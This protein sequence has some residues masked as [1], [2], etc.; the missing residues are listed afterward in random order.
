MPI[1]STSISIEHAQIDGRRYVTE[2]H[3]DH[4]GVDHRITYL[5]EVGTDY[6]SVAAA[7][8]SQIEIALAE[9]EI[10]E[11]LSNG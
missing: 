8:V 4:L 9:Q 11:I 3:T 1:I 2:A 5:S 10:N 6:A 7:R